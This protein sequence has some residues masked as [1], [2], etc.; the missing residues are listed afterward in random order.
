MRIVVA[1]VEM[2]AQKR[3]AANSCKPRKNVKLAAEALAPYA[4]NIR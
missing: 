4:L 3:R 1:L 2:L